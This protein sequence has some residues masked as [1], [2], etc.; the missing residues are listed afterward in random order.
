[1]E[2]AYEAGRRDAA[3]LAGQAAFLRAVPNAPSGPVDT[4][5]LAM[6]KRWFLI[7]MS[8]DPDERGRANAAVMLAQISGYEAM[9][10]QQISGQ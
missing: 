10:R 7:A 8:E 3:A 2:R 6:A 9:A 1:M 4:E 5:L